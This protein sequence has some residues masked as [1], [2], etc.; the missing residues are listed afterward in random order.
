MVGYPC[1][2]EGRTNEYVQRPFEFHRDRRHR[3]DPGRRPG[4]IG[5]RPERGP[6]PR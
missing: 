5:R 6:W 1:S 4:L 2:S 3:H